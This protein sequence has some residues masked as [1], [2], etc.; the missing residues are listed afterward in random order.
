V[1][2]P[3][4]ESSQ[5]GKTQNHQRHKILKK[6]T[7]GSFP[8]KILNMMGHPTVSL[9]DSPGNIENK[10]AASDSPSRPDFH[11]THSPAESE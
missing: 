10:K 2:S 1:R 3:S 8:G 7:D 5:L 6:E 9:P 11:R 4:P